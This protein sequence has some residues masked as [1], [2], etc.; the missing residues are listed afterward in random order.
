M[1][2]AAQRPDTP[3]IKRTEVEIEKALKRS[4]RPCARD[5]VMVN[6]AQGCSFGCLFCPVQKAGHSAELKLHVN[7]PA[8][9]E[10]ELSA[11]RRQGTLPRGAFFS[12]L[13]DAF[14][15][16]ERLLDLTHASM[17]VLLEAGL[18]VHFVTRGV[19]PESFGE[20]FRQ[21]RDRIFPQ[22][23]IF[24]IDE[25]LATLYEPGAASP[26]Q[27]LDGIRQLNRWGV[28]VLG[29]M[30]PLVPFVSDTAGHMEELL[31]YFGSV[32]VRGVSASYL[33]LHP[34]MLE[35]FEA[36]L[37]PVHFNLIKGSFKGQ[38]WRKTGLHQMSK[39]LPDR[40]RQQGY[41]R[42]Q[43]IAKRLAIAVSICAC[44]DPAVGTSCL[45]PTRRGPPATAGRKGQ[46]EL[47]GAG[48]PHKG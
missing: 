13:T 20:L 4:R 22:V 43:N 17:R 48:G 28:S 11:R 27:R 16:D 26:Q 9:L 30:E 37:P 5:L 29:R 31:R 3:A 14:Q 24:S 44:Q 8:L 1:Y 21:F 42:L 18:E 47:F 34:A 23:K 25:R 46:L 2:S 6:P 39:Y 45:A 32:D 41:A 36:L 33:I 12:T 38:T 40:I 7:L 35:G 15:A 10:H 19:V